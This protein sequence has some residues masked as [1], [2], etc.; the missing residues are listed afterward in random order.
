MIGAL[1]STAVLWILMVTI[2]KDEMFGFRQALI[3]VIIGGLT[4]MLVFFAV[5]EITKLA[6][7]ARIAGIVVALL[8]IYLYL[9]HL[10]YNRSTV[11][12]V[13]VYYVIISVA[14]SGIH[15][16]MDMPI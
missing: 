2:A 13:L 1:I 6:L 8:P 14:L 16:L 7:L 3:A 9:T 11:L 12:R 5:A 4:S 10:G 15:F